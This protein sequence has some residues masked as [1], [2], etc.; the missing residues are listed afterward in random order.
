MAV[1]DNSTYSNYYISS[2]NNAT[3]YCPTTNVYSHHYWPYMPYNSSTSSVVKRKRYSDNQP[4]SK[5]D[6]I[7]ERIRMIEVALAKISSIDCGHDV[8]SD[9]CVVCILRDA[10]SP[11]ISEVMEWL[12]DG[13]RSAVNTR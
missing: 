7:S 5:I 3:V 6:K 4:P 9:T 1:G 10:I 11:L 2:S 8:S 13:G 12:A